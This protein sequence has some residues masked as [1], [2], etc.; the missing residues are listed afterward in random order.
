MLEFDIWDNLTYLKD[1]NIWYKQT[2]FENELLKYEDYLGN[3]WTPEFGEYLLPVIEFELNAFSVLGKYILMI[4]HEDGKVLISLNSLY[5]GTKGK[6]LLDT[7]YVSAP[8]VPL[9]LAPTIS[10]SIMA[11]NMALTASCYNKKVVNSSFYGTINVINPD[12][13]FTITEGLIT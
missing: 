6:S 10:D 4:N 12:T 9:T 3:Y 13:V 8:F 11:M 5:L 2:F 7:G 1:G